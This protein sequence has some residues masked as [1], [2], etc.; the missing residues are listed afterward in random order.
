M[1]KMKRFLCLA[2]T[3]VMA[4]T[5]LIGCGK[6]DKQHNYPVN[7]IQA[8]ATARLSFSWFSIFATYQPTPIFKDGRGPHAQQWTIG[9][10]F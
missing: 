5:M 3:L 8:G 1:K 9:I 4:A 6:K 7:F 10:G 2:L